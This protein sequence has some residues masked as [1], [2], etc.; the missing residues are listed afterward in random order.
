MAPM[1]RETRRCVVM[2]PSSHSAVHRRRIGRRSGRYGSGVRDRRSGRLQRSHPVAVGS[3]CVDSALR[4][5]GAPRASAPGNGSS[6]RVQAGCEPPKG[7][8][9]IGRVPVSKT[10]GWGFESLRPCE[11]PAPVLG[12]SRSLRRTS[13]A[14]RTD[15]QVRDVTETRANPT[16]ARDREAR[17]PLPAADLAVLPPGHRR[18]AQ[19]HLA[20]AQ[21]AGDLHHGGHRLRAASSSPTSPCSTSASARRSSRSS[22]SRRPHVLRTTPHRS[23][24]K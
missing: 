14:R 4:W 21:G 20:D 15:R 5:P 11:E 19:G 9:S 23:V 24:R 16:P 3:L 10:G 13:R 8:S 18:A 1:R 7:R 17:K 2:A 12:R 6:S 22:A